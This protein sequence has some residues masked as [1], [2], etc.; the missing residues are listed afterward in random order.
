MS[1]RKI[2]GKKYRNCWKKTDLPVRNI[3]SCQ[4]NKNEKNHIAVSMIGDM[5]KNRK[6]K[7]PEKIPSFLAATRG[8][9]PLFSP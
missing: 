7:N 3:R 5:Q 8:I 9:E 2:K 1:P 4:N 6:T